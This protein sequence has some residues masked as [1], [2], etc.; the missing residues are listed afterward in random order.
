MA[1]SYW[2]LA[3]APSLS[4]CNADKAVERCGMRF[5]VGVKSQ[6]A[7][8][9]PALGAQLNFALLPYEAQR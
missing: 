6:R 5:N 2:Q 9:V 3:G 8:A 7:C 4:V 1:V